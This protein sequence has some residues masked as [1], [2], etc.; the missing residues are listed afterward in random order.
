MTHLT[1][2]HLRAFPLALALVAGASCWSTA[3]FAQSTPE[4]PTTTT[5]TQP[6]PSTDTDTVRLTDKERMEILDKNTEDSA[7]AAR[8][9]LT[10]SGSGGRGIHGEL[11]AMIGSHGTRGAYG[12]AEIPLGDNAAATVSI[13]SSRFGYPR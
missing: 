3:S 12:A 8:G 10:G 6:A 9:E 7:A 4:P 13:E 11:G 1:Q 5:T 2:S